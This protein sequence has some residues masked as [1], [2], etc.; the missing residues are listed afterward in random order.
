M[1]AAWLAA[2]L[3]TGL[4]AGLLGVGGGLL[5]IPL[6]NGLYGWQGV[7]A[8]LIQ[9]LAL[10]TSLAVIVPTGLMSARAHAARGALDAE[11]LRRLAGWVA[12]GALLAACSSRWLSPRLLQGLYVALCVWVL[13]SLWRPQAAQV[14][15]LALPTLRAP[16]LAG[17]IIGTLSG[18]LGIGGGTL[19]TPYLRSQA[20]SMHVS[21]ATAA[22]L[23]VPIA[24]AGAVGYVVAG[25]QVAGR[26]PLA[27]GFVDL[28]AAAGLLAGS[29]LAAPLGV[30]LAHRLNSAQLRLAFSLAVVLGGGKML[31]QLLSS[32]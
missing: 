18:W 3:F 17:L 14:S 22:G 4:L 6:L 15:Q 32:A 24:L 10:G 12:C 25:W 31:L 9:H 27:V 16:R 29:L 19:S 13:F 30:A 8:H 5:M 11:A 21:V 26:P 28:Q 2:G 23:G 7:P 20:R 1:L